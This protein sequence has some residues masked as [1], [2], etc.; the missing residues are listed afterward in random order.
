MTAC[1]DIGWIAGGEWLEYTIDVEKAGAHN[2]ACF[3][4]RPL[5]PAGPLLSASTGPA[6][7]DVLCDKASIDSPQTAAGTTFP[8]AREA[9]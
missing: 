5:A 1:G 3:F 8:A 6:K 9:P 2:L 7:N 4:Q